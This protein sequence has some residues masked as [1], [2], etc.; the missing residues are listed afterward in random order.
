MDGKARGWTRWM[1]VGMGVSVFFAL[2]GFAAA[3]LSSESATTTI[4]PQQNGT[5]TAKCGGGST[6]VAGGFAAPGLDPTAETGPAIL[7][8]ASAFVPGEKWQASGHNFNRPAPA[9]ARGTTSGS[10]PLVAYAYC[11]RHDPSVTINSE[12]ADRKSVV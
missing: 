3:R 4:A 9:P 10:G 12:V 8:Y 7:T 11:D 1:A 5:A 6:A 2:T